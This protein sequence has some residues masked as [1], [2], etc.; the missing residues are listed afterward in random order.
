M[1]D[2]LYRWFNIIYAIQARPGIT[3]PELAQKCD[4]DVR[5]IYRDLRSLDT[6]APIV[7]DGYGKGYTFAGDFAMYP[8]NWTPQEELVFTMLP[9]ILDHTQLPPGFE[10]A[11]D[12]IMAARTREKRRNQDILKHVTDIIQMGS[13]AYR[14]D[15]PNHLLPVIQAILAEQTLSVTYHT[16]SRN[17]LTEREIDPYYLIPRDQRFYLIGYCH[18]AGQIRTFRLSRFRKL[19]VTARS[20]EKGDFNLANYMKH[21]WSIERGTGQITFKVK[22]SRE[23]ARYIKEEE[24]FV[25]PKMTDLPDG[26]LLFEVTL[27]H[28]REFLNWVN[29]YGPDAEILE[30]RSYR[31]MMQEKLSRWRGLYGE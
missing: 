19:E 11:Y 3:A 22:F 5:T 24:M 8:L 23:V 12:K 20:F 16:Q 21:T 13:P 2:K 30:P 15:S 18:L 14:E 7:N 28:D 25:R 4:V 17:E 1:S 10:S 29:Q 6:L 27:N 31:K 26:S 9:S